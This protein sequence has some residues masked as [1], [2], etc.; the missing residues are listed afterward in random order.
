[1]FNQADVYTLLAALHT[2]RGERQKAL[3]AI[4]EAARRA[5]KVPNSSSEM[6]LE[7][8]TIAET[9]LRLWEMLLAESKSSG[10]GNLC[11][12]DVL[13]CRQGASKACKALGSLS[14]IFPIGGSFTLLWSALYNYMEGHSPKA[15]AAWTKSLAAA[16]NLKMSYAEGLAEYELGR[17]L[18]AHDE[19]RKVHL[20]KASDIFRQV[21]AAYDQSK[22]EEA[23]RAG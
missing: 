3:E 19:H 16:K 15:N 17:H 14:R 22:V 18:Q 1:M 12:A 20:Q 6:I 9:Y 11:A 8:A 13:R 4:D 7:R 5:L 23:L 21:G 10:S 2:R